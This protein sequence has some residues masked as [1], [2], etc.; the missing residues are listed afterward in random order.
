MQLLVSPNLLRENWKVYKGN[1]EICW[2]V[3]WVGQFGWV[4]KRLN[5][6][7]L[8]SQVVGRNLHSLARRLWGGKGRA[9]RQMPKRK[10]WNPMKGKIL[11]GPV[12]YNCQRG[13]S[14][15]AQEYIYIS[16]LEL[17]RLILIL[18]YKLLRQLFQT[19][20]PWTRLNAIFILSSPYYSV[21]LLMVIKSWHWFLFF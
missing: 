10:N 9:A 21:V 17:G 20:L 6:T 8:R 4:W 19:E 11:C 2:R 14:M 18:Y 16:N 3:F 13:R 12:R 5:S 15:A 7:C 1:L